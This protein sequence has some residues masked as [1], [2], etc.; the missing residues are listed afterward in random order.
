MP[1]KGNYIVGYKKPPVHTQFKKGQSGNPKGRPKS[2]QSMLTK[3]KN[4]ICLLIK[5]LKAL[6]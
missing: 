5:E 1:K 3:I 6:K 4:D 2:K